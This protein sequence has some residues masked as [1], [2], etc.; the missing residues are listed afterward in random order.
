MAPV[1]QPSSK[2]AMYV[3][4]CKAVTDQDIRRAVSRGADTFEAAQAQTGCSTCC[5]CCEGEARELVETAVASER[6]AA[7]LPVAA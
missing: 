6:R 5:G 3:C 7:A 2:A 4:I 1:E